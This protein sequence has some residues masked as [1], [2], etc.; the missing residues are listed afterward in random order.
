MTAWPEAR[1]IAHAAAFELAPERIPVGAAAGRTLAQDLLALSDLP[2]FD[3]AA[4]D[5]WAVCGPGP[6]TVI[7]RVLAGD[8]PP[9]VRLEDGEALE[10][11]TGAVVPL[12]CGGV[13]PYEGGSPS[14]PLVGGAHPVGRH[15][16]MR[17]EECAAGDLLLESG[18]LLSA[19]AVGLAAA[20]GHDRLLVRRR[21]RVTVLVTGSE[22]LQSGLPQAGRIRDAVGPLLRPALESMG[23]HVL[24][25]EHLADHRGSLA[26]ALLA[27]T[28]VVVT[29][30]ASSGGPADHLSGVLAELG[31]DV[32][33][34]GVRVVPG[35]PQLL[36]RL[37][38][39]P[40]VVGL[41]GNPLAA[42]AGIV[43]L[44]A[45]L[46]LGLR[47]LPLASPATAEAGQGFDAHPASYRLVP[48][49]V[50]HGL[51]TPVGHA[52]S[53]MLRGAAAANAF[54]VVGAGMS[55]LAGEELAFLP[56]P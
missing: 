14:G 1:R 52:G 32:L 40:L 35:H 24:A 28:D 42:L 4:M 36:A 29:T 25:A 48:V 10:V 51:A 18:M 31:A 3:A 46:M 34:D 53:G 49:Q 19:A 54:A 23:A 55:V 27:D 5:G 22:L 15:I 30:G 21:P 26:R 16:R 37:P 44:L 39:G 6:W 7:G 11:A 33:V 38:D 2:P 8:P 43:T 47:G 17:G 50:L 56:L 45:P 12:G 41:P 13:L 20:S 9:P